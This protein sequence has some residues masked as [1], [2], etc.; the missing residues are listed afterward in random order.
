ML[1]L[2]GLAEGGQSAVGRQRRDI[3][4]AEETRRVQRASAVRGRP[5]RRPDH[6]SG[7][8]DTTRLGG[9]DAVDLQLI[10]HRLYAVWRT[11]EKRKYIIQITMHVAFLLTDLFTI[12]FCTSPTSI[13]CT[14]TLNI[15]AK[16]R[17]TLCCEEFSIR[18]VT[19]ILYI[20]CS[21]IVD[22][23][24]HC[25]HNSLLNCTSPRA[26]SSVN[27]IYSETFKKSNCAPQLDIR[28]SYA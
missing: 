13:S 17:H 16:N 20:S 5:V 27:L 18:N 14:G 15:F 10:G 28:F 25:V 21:E 6:R 4:Q 12:L 26:L 22:V 9:R 1:V 3:R 23:R 19:S 24:T 7:L 8:S 2:D 11:P